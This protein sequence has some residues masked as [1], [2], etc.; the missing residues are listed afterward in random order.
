MTNKRSK[1]LTTLFSRVQT[2]MLSSR[3][4]VG[5]IFVIFQHEIRDRRWHT[6]GEIRGLVFYRVVAQVDSFPGQPFPPNDKCTDDSRKHTILRLEKMRHSG[7]RVVD[8]DEEEK[9]RLEHEKM[10]ALYLGPSKAVKH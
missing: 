4:N 2:D 10:G 1:P 9:D 6:L 5:D 8:F 7:G 3:Y